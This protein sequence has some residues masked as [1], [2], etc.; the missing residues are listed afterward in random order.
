MV[1]FLKEIFLNSVTLTHCSMQLE[2][3]VAQENN[4][5]RDQLLTVLGGN[6]PTSTLSAPT[7]TDPGAP[8]S[9]DYED[10]DAD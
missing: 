4:L 10:N 5:T 2:K 8:T 9:A 3:I 6:A 7:G 1:L